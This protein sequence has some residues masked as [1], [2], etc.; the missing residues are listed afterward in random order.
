MEN[1]PDRVAADHNLAVRAASA[2]HTI[3]ATGTHFSS[4]YSNTNDRLQPHQSTKGNWKLPVIIVVCIVGAILIA[5]AIF[6]LIKRNKRGASYRNLEKPNMGEHRDVFDARITEALENDSGHS[7]TREHGDGDYA[8]P[9]GDADV[10]G[11]GAGSYGDVDTSY[12]GPE[13]TYSEKAQ[14]HGA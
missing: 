2:G 13:K 6:F 4:Y 1:L 3:L 8:H 12:R 10:A 7:L 14:D 9:Y 5:A 11:R